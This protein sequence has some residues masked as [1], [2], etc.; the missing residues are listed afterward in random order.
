MGFLFPEQEQGDPREPIHRDAQDE[1]VDSELAIKN[2][3]DGV[4]EEWPNEAGVSPRC[5]DPL[6]HR[7]LCKH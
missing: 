1:K 5:T 4:Y 3:V 7:M 2:L 6:I